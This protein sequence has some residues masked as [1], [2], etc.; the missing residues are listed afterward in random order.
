MEIDNKP[1]KPKQPDGTGYLDLP[2]ELRQ[3]ILDYSYESKEVEFAEWYE[4]YMYVDWVN[5]LR[6]VHEVVAEDVGYME[7]RWNKKVVIK[8]W[9]ESPPSTA[10]NAESAEVAR[11]ERLRRDLHPEFR[12]GEM[13]GGRLVLPSAGP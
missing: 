7:K 4:A 13:V 8:G 9:K 12:M 10:T 1:N 6:Q 11:L 2:R 5:V 3:I